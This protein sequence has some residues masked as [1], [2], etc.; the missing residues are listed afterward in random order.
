MLRAA[1]VGQLFELAQQF[2]LA[3]GQLDRRLDHAMAQQVAGLTGAHALDPFAAQPERF[4]GLCAFGQRE[5]G[6]ATKC[7]HFDLTT[8]CRLRIRNRNL[9][10]QVIAFALKYR[11]LLDMNL[12]IQVAR[13]TTVHTWLAIARRTNPHAVID[14]GRNLH[15]QC[16]VR[17]ATSAGGNIPGLLPTTRYRENPAGAQAS[18]LGLL[19]Q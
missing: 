4:A 15:F 14:T 2:A 13:R 11:V 1:F 10:M 19:F 12:D 9:A 16:L 6:L 7:G 17:E 18:L 8:E 5:R 3:L